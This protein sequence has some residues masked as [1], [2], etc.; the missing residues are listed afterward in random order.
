MARGH[1]A[2]PVSLRSFLWVVA[3]LLAVVELCVDSFG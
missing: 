3:L 1:S 2:H